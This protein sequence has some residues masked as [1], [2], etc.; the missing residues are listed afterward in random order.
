MTTFLTLVYL[1]CFQTCAWF[2]IA[3]VWRRRSS[4]DLSLWREWFLIV[5]V[6]AQFAVMWRT[7]A[8]WRVLISPIASGTSIAALLY[9]VYR[10]RS[11]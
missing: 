3:R 2:S 11:D 10:F 1:T 7:G 4:S 9:V 5:G 6:T 8:D